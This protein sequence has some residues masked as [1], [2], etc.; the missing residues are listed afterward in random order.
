[1]TLSDCRTEIELG[2]ALG[3][4]LATGWMAD[5]GLMGTPDVTLADRQTVAP[6]VEFRGDV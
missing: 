1:V 6:D 3:Y 2:V 5:R 4:Y